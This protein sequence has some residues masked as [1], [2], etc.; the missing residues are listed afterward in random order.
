MMTSNLSQSFSP[1]AVEISF[2]LHTKRR[3]NAP[4][5]RQWMFITDN[6]TWNAQMWLVIRK[7]GNTVKLYIFDSYLVWRIQLIYHY[8]LYMFKKLWSVQGI[9]NLKWESI[10]FSKS[11]SYIFLNK[12]LKPVFEN[13][14]NHI[15]NL[16]SCV[17]NSQRL[18]CIPK[19]GMKCFLKAF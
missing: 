2:E 1:W 18:F 15:L 4:H 17:V 7:L 11:D 10:A 19:T 16:Y 5:T 3:G 12:L 8:I 14:I 13:K 6:Y 9:F